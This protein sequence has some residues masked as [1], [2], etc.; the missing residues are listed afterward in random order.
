MEKFSEQ[1]YDLKR[2]V[3]SGQTHSSPENLGHSISNGK[4]N[5]GIRWYN[6]TNT[7]YS[8]KQK[9]KQQCPVNSDTKLVNSTVKSCINES[10]TISR[11][12][13]Y[14]KS[15]IPKYVHFADTV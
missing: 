7:K 3:V 15:N 9:V 5:P 13:L 2:E 14:K 8:I 4:I 10:R 1:F 12:A 11:S 6:G